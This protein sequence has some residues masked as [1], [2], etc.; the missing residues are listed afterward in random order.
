MKRDRSFVAHAVSA[1]IPTHLR[2]HL[3]VE[4]IASILS[5]TRLPAEIIVVDDAN[6]ED[7]RQAVHDAAAQASVQVTY[8]ENNARRG[9]CGSRNLGAANASSPYIA[10]LDDDDLWRPTFLEEMLRTILDA[11]ADFAMCGL[12][13]FE[14]GRAPELRSTPEG[15][16]TLDVVA[17]PRSMTG[18]NVLYRREVFAAVGGFDPSVPVF[19]DWDLFIRLIDA[20]FSYRVVPSGLADWR[21]HSGDRIAT[22]SLKRAAGLRHFLMKY[23]KRM[24]QSTYRDFMTTAIGIERRHATGF[25]RIRKSAELA[26]A[27]GIV[28]TLARLLDASPANT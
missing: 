12:Y 28:R 26:K 4:A 25:V 17:D 14:D 15:L 18:S 16:T 24:K 22:F 7:T 5:Q 8:I 10:F 19:N 23:G 1:V 9:A 6:D 11:S 21:W 13:R 2:P 20:G 27:H 3:L